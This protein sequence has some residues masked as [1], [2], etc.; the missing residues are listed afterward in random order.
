[1]SRASVGSRPGKVAAAAV[2]ATMIPAGTCLALGTGSTVEASLQMLADIPGLVATPSSEAI[3]RHAKS[4]GLRLV[5]LR[6]EYDFYLDG[7]DQVAP[8]GDV[9]K[10]SWGAHVRE[11]TLAAL[12]KQRILICDEGKLVD[13][14]TGPIPV[15]VIP[16]FAG[17]YTDSAPRTDENG[18]A[19]VDAAAGETI[20]SAA[21]WDEWMRMQPGVVL[22]GLFPAGFVQQIIIGHGD[23]T[24][25]IHAGAR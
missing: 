11:K 5:P 24:T 19:I 6:R 9:V 21:E 23:G 7:A 15:A 22:T 8:N 13:K 18:L 2:A 10:G 1:M 4:A 3:A 16:F 17:L 14:L 12:A 20:E 25:S